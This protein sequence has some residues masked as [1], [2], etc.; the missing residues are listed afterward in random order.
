MH[1]LLVALTLALT[2]LMAASSSAGFSVRA[3]VSACSACANFKLENA[4]QQ[5]SAREARC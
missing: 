5:S 4:A 3:R 2:W 1:L